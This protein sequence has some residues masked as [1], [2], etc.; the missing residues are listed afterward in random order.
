MVSDDQADLSKLPK[1]TVG[2]TGTTA[3]LDEAAIVA[4]T[5]V[6]GQI[7]YVND[8]FCQISGYSREE[9]LGANH[10]LLR[11]G[12]HATEFFREMYRVIASGRT[13]HGELCNKAKDGA[14]YWVDT[15]IVPRRGLNG[16][17]AFYD[18]IRFDITP[19]K[20]A[21]R[22]LW[23]EARTD[24]LTGLPNRLHFTEL[25]ANE[26]AISEKTGASFAVA[27]LDLD[28]FKLMNDSLG[29]EAGDALLTFVAKKLVELLG[30]ELIVAR[31]GGDEF[32]LIIPNADDNSYLTEI[33]DKVVSALRE[34]VTIGASDHRCSASIG[35]S[36]F[37]KHAYR[38]TDLLKNADIA[39]Y[40]A[41]SRGRDRFEVFDPSMAIAIAQRAT[42]NQQVERALR[43]QEFRLFFQPIVDAPGTRKSRITG[44]EALLR[45]QHPEWGLVAP[46]RFSDV[47]DDAALCKAIGRFVVQS[48]IDQASD[49]NRLGL[50]FQ[51]IAINVTAA[52]FQSDG[53]GSSI[54]QMIQ[55]A[56]LETQN[57]CI[58]VTE[59]MFLGRGNDLIRASLVKLHEAG[60]KIALDDFGTG[61]ASLTHL[62]SLPIDRIKIDRSFVEQIEHDHANRTIVQGLIQIAHSLGLQVT[63][64]GV[65]TYSQLEELRRF[66]CDQIQGYLIAKPMHPSHIPYFVAQLEQTALAEAS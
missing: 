17:I 28:G 25:L 5:D 43:R 42:L 56:Q 14:Q 20:R 35:V 37:A 18:A 36:I 26:I 21:E 11:S 31:L 38:A 1:T 27:I 52:D 41:K 7:L 61:F 23:T 66:G 47:F 24:T 4:T 58:E 40:R 3:A 51:K 63:A 10:R 39:L 22:L 60:L 2:Q 32:T 59:G 44:M 45:W 19:L 9:L 46:G 29:H 54:L 8:K 65:E 30:E 6:K 49:W 64:E 48:A 34:P 53:V 50:Q 16:K 33:L 62:K 12:H 57:F 15:T 55:N 13:W